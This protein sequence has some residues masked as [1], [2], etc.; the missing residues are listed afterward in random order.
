ME[1]E[2][3]NEDILVIDENTIYEIDMNCMK[4][5]TENCH[6]EEKKR[7]K[8]EKKAFDEWTNRFM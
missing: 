8:Y 2:K 1:R 4:C 6:K 5:K 3:E 7:E